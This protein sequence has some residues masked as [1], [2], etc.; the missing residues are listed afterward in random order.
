MRRPEVGW[1]IES[2]VEFPSPAFCQ[3]ESLPDGLCKIG[4]RDGNLQAQRLY[5]HAL[6]DGVIGFVDLF[7]NFHG[8]GALVLRTAKMQE[9][10][11]FRPWGV[12]PI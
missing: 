12:H 8:I 9:T 1:G 7:F 3:V 4:P 11:S 10:S 6:L 5:G 2:E